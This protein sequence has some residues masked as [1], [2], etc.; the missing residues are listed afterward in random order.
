[1]CFNV[2]ITRQSLLSIKSTN[3]DALQKRLN[4]VLRGRKPTNYS[5]RIIV[6]VRTRWDPN[7]ILTE[8]R[9]ALRY[10][11]AGRNENP[12][13]M[14]SKSAVGSRLSA[15]YTDNNTAPVFAI[16]SMET[17]S[18]SLFIARRLTRIIIIIIIIR[19]ALYSNASAAEKRGKR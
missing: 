10:T 11:R 13:R 5:P 12:S 7:G 17:A 8:T 9:V 3:H 15:R 4:G 14:P 1:M 2:L 6:R 16:I 19:I 18:R